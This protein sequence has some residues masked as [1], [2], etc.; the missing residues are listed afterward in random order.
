MKLAAAFRWSDFPLQAALAL[1][2]GLL[3]KVTLVLFPTGVAAIVWPSSGLALAALLLG[4]RKYWPAILIGAFAASLMQGDSAAISLFIAA[5]RT[6]EALACVWLLAPG[7]RFDPALNQLQDYARLVSAAAIGAGASV[8]ISTTASWLFGLLA[9]PAIAVSLLYGWQGDV[10]GIA[11]VTPLVLVWRTLPQGWF[12]RERLAE[13]VAC[14]GLAFLFG[15]AA[16]LGL[17]HD[18]FG[19]AIQD[20]WMFMFVI[21]SAL[22]FGRH[23][24]LLVVAMM[25]VQALLGSMPHVPAAPFYFWLDMLSLPLIGLSLALTITE[26]NRGA[27]TLRTSEERLKIATDSGQIAV[28]EVDL[29][30][31]K[32][33]WDDICFTLYKIPRESFSGNFDEWAERLHPEDLAPTLAAFEKAAAGL[34]DYY[35]NFR[36]RWPDGEV[37]YITGRSRLIRDRAGNPERMIGTNWD[38]TGLKQTE[39]A[40]RAS[41][42]RLKLATASGQI[43]IWEYD[44]GSRKLT[45]DDTMLSLYGVRRDD[46]AGTY[47][48]WAS[49]L[50]P[51]D[52]AATEAALQDAIAD[53]KDYE[54]EFRVI[55]PDGTVSYIKGHAHVIRDQAGNPESMIGTNWDNRAHALTQQQ[56][57]MAHAAINKSRSAFFWLNREGMVTDVNDA[58]CRSLGY[59]REELLGMHVWD[60]DPD[61]PPEA[62]APMWEGLRKTRVVNIET[63][64]RRK[65]GTIFPVEVVGNLFNSEDQEYSFVFVQDIS[66]RKM[67]EEALQIAAA[68]FETHEGIMITDADANII[69]VNQAFQN[70]SGYNAQEVIGKNPRILSSGRHDAAFYAGM[71]RHLLNEGSWTGEIWDQRK[72]GQVY[73]KWMTITAVRN[74]QGKTTQYVA[75]FSDITE[76]KRAEEEIRSLAFYDS[77]TKLPNRRLLL[78]RLQLALSVSVRSHHYGAVLFL[79]LDKFKTI[80]DTLGHDYGDLLL[81]EVAERIKLCVREAD[82]VARLGGDEFVVVLEEISTSAEDASQKVALIADKIR[83]ALIAPFLIKGREQHSSTSIGVCLY[84]ENRE[85]ADDLLK[86]ADMA[87]YQAK[88]SGRNAVRFFDPLMQQAVETRTSLEVDLR[89]AVPNHQLRLYYQIQMDN[90]QRPVGAEALVRWICPLRGLVSPMQFIPIA[91]ES[92]L[93]LDI[94]HWV[95]ETACR[96]LEEWGRNAHTRGLILAINIS[97]QQ[98]R[99]PDFVERVAAVVR[100][101]HFPPSR[102]KL[103]LT[104]SVVLNDVAGV[105]EKM[106]LL[107]A[108]GIKLSLDD[109]GTGYSSLSYLK[110]LPLD[111]IKI[112]QSFVRDIT[113]DANDAVM[114]QAIIHMAMNFGLEVIAEG[115]ETD[116]QLAFLRQHGCMAYQGYLFGKPL[117]IEEFEALLKRDLENAGP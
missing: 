56:L 110:R 108:L 96:Q 30:T 44:M 12:G 100:S 47:E 71:W 3:A 52:R 42:E 5:G 101:H 116:A 69:R 43:G 63:R 84:Y 51:E 78:D 67:A 104:E 49:R 73:L 18:L 60:F 34:G 22:R 2:Y 82:T 31:G 64:H 57:Q 28:W 26:R 75:I 89:R 27:Q 4:G 16:F 33:T 19:L 7:T 87:M 36:I 53:I 45:W 59:D 50:H 98:F 113:T 61:F 11:L 105:I 15:Q 99:M 9:T 66:E 40:L 94:G 35:P 74:K 54:P 21:W 17:F 38:I 86:Q 20:P 77:L 14:F 115:V 23:G 103:E 102:L 41:E 114:V 37:R 111:Q 93:I 13:T 109:F 8:L 1:A 88:D 25:V 107:G 55:R 76:W 58:A 72:N 70:I 90:D 65:D 97:A 29:K 62:W 117:P 83:A 106:R 81:I 92:A 112:D 10:F 68:T 95:L 48:A 6:L 80:N 79:D 91:E 39:A 32:L 85:S 46:F 24:V